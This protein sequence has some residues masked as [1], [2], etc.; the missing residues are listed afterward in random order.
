MAEYNLKNRTIFCRDNLDVLRGINSN[1]VDL[2]YLDP[3]FN[4]KKIFTAPI[5]S[6]SEG[7]SFSDIFRKED[8]KEE[9]LYLIEKKHKKTHSLIEGVR[10][11]GNKYN[12]CYLSYMAVR[13]MEMNRILKDTGSLYLHCD[14]TMSHYLKL[15]LDC[16]FGEENF[17]NEVVWKRTYAH[18]DPKKFG[19]NQDN[20]LFFTKSDDYQFNIGYTPYSEEYLKKNFRNKDARGKY[21]TVVLTGPGINSNDET[22]REY[23]PSQ[24]NRSWSIPKRI[25]N[26]LVGKEKAKTMSIIERLDLLYKNDYILISKNGIP[27]FKEYL[28]EMPGSPLQE[29]WTD[30]NPVSSQAKER[31]GYP[32]QKP[33]SLLER[34]IK[35]SSNQGDVVLDPFCGCATTC[36]ASDRLNRKWAGIDVSEKAYE[37]VNQRLSDTV[38]E[39]EIFKP[40]VIL[41][42]DIPLRTDLEKILKHNDTKNKNYLYGEQGGNCN[43]CGTHFEKRHFEV[44]HI[45]SKKKG[46]TDHLENLQLLCGNCN[47]RKGSG[48]LEDLLAKLRKEG[49][50]KKSY[51]D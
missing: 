49:V 46:G 40:K 10:G 37:L 34:I 3:P 14:P 19:K 35:A 30:I 45:I 43:A 7:A 9:W 20:I 17:R 33:L 2:I 28:C 48:S 5:G 13:L 1:C 31:T 12:W 11:F 32:T 44:D 8:V 23:H 42:D 4:K 25:I 21:R 15:L 41:R 50:I 29:I 51:L 26:K 22:W 24:S 18:N 16:T 39:I 6:S 38:K 27:N 36:V 47:K